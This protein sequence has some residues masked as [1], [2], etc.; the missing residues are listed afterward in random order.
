MSNTNTIPYN[1]W[2]GGRSL[3]RTTTLSSS[4]QRVDNPYTIANFQ[5]NCKVNVFLYD[6]SYITNMRRYAQR[7]IPNY[8]TI[9]SI[10]SGYLPTDINTSLAKDWAYAFND[11]S[12][13][14]SLPDPFYDTSNATN[15]SD[16]FAVSPITRATMKVKQIIFPLAF[17]R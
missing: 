4:P 10:P 12:N 14:T 6:N 11:C 9:T 5:Y 1:T 15:M 3:Y 8:N 16:M 7:N 17:L 2:G 13:L